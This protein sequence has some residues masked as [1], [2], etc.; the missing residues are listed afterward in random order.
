ME[1]IKFLITLALFAIFSFFMISFITKIFNKRINKQKAFL[2]IVSKRAKSLLEKQGKDQATRFIKRNA[3]AVFE[4]HDDSFDDEFK[5]LKKFIH[6]LGD[7]YTE[8]E[9]IILLFSGNYKK[10]DIEEFSKLFLD[11]L[12]PA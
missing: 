10:E 2:L 11:F 5:I 6:N 4:L 7:N 3:K 12:T 8:E 1:P 9:I